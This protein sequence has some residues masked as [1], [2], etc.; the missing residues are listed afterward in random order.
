MRRILEFVID[1]EKISLPVRLTLRAARIYRTEFGRDLIR[2]LTETQREISR[3]IQQAL[4]S[5]KLPPQ[6]LGLE[7]DALE[8][9]V[10]DQVDLSSVIAIEPLADGQ[11]D[12]GAQCIWAFAKNADEDLPEFSKWLDIFDVVL[13]VQELCSTLFELWHAATRTTIEIKN[14]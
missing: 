6:A 7:G 1:E 8:K 12:I 2:D 4:K 11:I 5:V 14:G 9:Y 13:P 10:L 3:P